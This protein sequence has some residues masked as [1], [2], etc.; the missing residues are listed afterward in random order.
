MTK[1][2]VRC[3]SDLLNQSPE[4]YESLSRDLERSN[5]S[6]ACVERVKKERGQSGPAIRRQTAQHSLAMGSAPA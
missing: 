6:P 5:S 1:A 2:A 4:L 3:R